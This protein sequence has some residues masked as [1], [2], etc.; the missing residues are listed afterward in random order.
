MRHP[1]N[2]RTT[3]TARKRYDAVEIHDL[4]AGRGSNVFSVYY[5]RLVPIS[6]QTAHVDRGDGHLGG[7]RGVD[8]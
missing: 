6:W 3:Q 1:G 7:T 5:E 4:G 8:A 2:K